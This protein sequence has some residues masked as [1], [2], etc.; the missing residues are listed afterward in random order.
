MRKQDLKIFIFT[1]CGIRRQPGS[2]MQEL[3]RE[4]SWRYWAIDVCKHLRV[5]RTLRMMDYVEQLKPLRRDKIRPTQKSP[6]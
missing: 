3:I 6:Q 4:G 5:T 2:G 1:T